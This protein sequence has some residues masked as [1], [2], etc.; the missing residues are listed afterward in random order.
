MTM[1]KMQMVMQ[2]QMQMMMVLVTAVVM[3][4]TPKQEKKYVIAKQENER[5]PGCSKTSKKSIKIERRN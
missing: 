3:I 2:M 1:M 5:K 4:A